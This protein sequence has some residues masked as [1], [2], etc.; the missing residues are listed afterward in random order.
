MAEQVGTLLWELRTAAGWSLGQLAQRAGVSKAALSQWESGL[1]QPRVPELEATLDALGATPAQ[2]SLVYARIEAPRALRFLNSPTAPEGPGPPPAAGDLLRAMRMRGSWTQE[3]IAHRVG[4]GQ[5][6]VARWERGERLPS[7][8]QMQALCFALAAHEEEIVVL[9][10]GRL[11]E[12]AETL[13]TDPQQ[14]L[15]CL[16]PLLYGPLQELADLR[17]LTIERELWQRTLQ[18]ERT[19]PLL[20]T[21]YAEHAHYLSLSARWEEVRTMAERALA[22]TPQEGPTPD[23]TLRAAL[24]LAEASVYGG[25]R[26]TPERGLRLLKTWLPRSSEAN[27]TGWIL[28]DMGEYM[29]LA[30]QREIA[31]DLSS[32]ALAITVDEQEMRLLDHGRVLV[33]TGQ[34]GKALDQL[35]SL[36]ESSRGMFV[37]EALIRC[38][39]YLSLGALEEA[40]AWLQRAYAVIEANGL[41]YNRAQADELARRLEAVETR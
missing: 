3:Q 24:K 11:T 7:S 31:L 36:P 1:R 10:M 5:N 41:K 4:V 9:T 15:D 30:G 12:A 29:A 39:A 35:P 22:L 18:D 16:H 40:S 14:M 38:E 26:P 8:E 25:H 33:A 13:P 21:A 6:T 34:P 17:F 37:Y 2:R 23:Y 19:R 32:R 28:S 20:A 27:F